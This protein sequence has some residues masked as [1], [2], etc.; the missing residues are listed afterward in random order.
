LY[1][2]FDIDS[3][4]D[5]TSISMSKMDFVEQGSQHSGS[6]GSDNT[7]ALL[8]A[9]LRDFEGD[10]E[11]L[12]ESVSQV[13]VDLGTPYQKSPK[14][15]VTSHRG[16]QKGHSSISSG[17]FSVNAGMHEV[18]Y[19]HGAMSE[20]SSVHNGIPEAF[21]RSQ[22]KR[23]VNFQGIHDGASNQHSQS[24]EQNKNFD[25]GFNSKR[26][27]SGN[28]RNEASYTPRKLS[29][30]SDNTVSGRESVIRHHSSLPEV[31]TTNFDRKQGRCVNGDRQGHTDQYLMN[32]VYITDA[33]CQIK[34]TT[35]NGSL[36]WGQSGLPRDNTQYMRDMNDHHGTVKGDLFIHDGQ[37]MSR[38]G[39][40][41][42][43]D[44]CSNGGTMRDINGKSRGEYD[45]HLGTNIEDFDGSGGMVRGITDESRHEYNGHSGSPKFGEAKFISGTA[46]GGR[47]RDGFY[48]GRGHEEMSRSNDRLQDSS[49][50]QRQNEEMLLG[51]KHDPETNGNWLL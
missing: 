38:H 4:S 50:E 17:G 9:S 44:V 19:V 48:D 51:V 45:R 47:N 25:Q 33:K 18:A 1:Q 12:L 14:A 7:D 23:S 21:P 40:G 3:I 29:S 20:V 30:D 34:P 13:D 15:R 10:D 8:N 11:S 41:N 35:G 2:G 43:G 37:N 32:S 28:L 36:P 46:G 49:L 26:E 5:I 22:N 39:Q 24:F 6:F 27:S 16:E 31:K 42:I